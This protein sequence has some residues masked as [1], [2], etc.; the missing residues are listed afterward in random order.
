M[1]FAI[2]I[3][4]IALLAACQTPP[5]PFPAAESGPITSEELAHSFDSAV[6]SRLIIFLNADRECTLSKAAIAAEESGEPE[7]GNAENLP[8]VYVEGAGGLQELS[9][10]IS[11]RELEAARLV[12]AAARECQSGEVN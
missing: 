5:P 3:S 12:G 9:N 1:R 8:R 6:S 7:P 4:S 2:A 10:D 11:N